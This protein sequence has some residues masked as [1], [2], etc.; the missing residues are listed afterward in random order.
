MCLPVRNFNAGRLDS[1]IE[2]IIEDHSQS[3]MMKELRKVED[4]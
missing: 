4:Q 1:Q 2:A 3:Y